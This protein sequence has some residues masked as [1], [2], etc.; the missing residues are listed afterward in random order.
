MNLY[1]L[2]ICIR[3]RF[4]RLNNFKQPLIQINK[5]KP[6]GFKKGEADFLT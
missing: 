6:K 2:L 5:K 3:G 1:F 4:I